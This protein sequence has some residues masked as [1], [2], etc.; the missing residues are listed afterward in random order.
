MKKEDLTKEQ[1]LKMIE[2]FEHYPAVTN[3][4]DEAYILAYLDDEACNISQVDI[5]EYIDKHFV[6]CSENEK[7][8]PIVDKFIKT[9]PKGADF[10]FGSNVNGIHNEDGT[11]WYNSHNEEEFFFNSL[12][13]LAK[14]YLLDD[15][16]V[17]YGYRYNCGEYDC[18]TNIYK[19]RENVVPAEVNFEE[20]GSDL[21]SHTK[22][23]NGYVSLETPE[24]SIIIENETVVHTVILFRVF[25]GIDDVL[26][27]FD[28]ELAE[29][30]VKGWANQNNTEGLTFKNSDDALEWFAN[31]DDK[32]ENSIELISS[33]VTTV[34]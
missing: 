31:N 12:E 11:A 6:S 24:A 13:D 7:I 20:D 16:S 33:T 25:G 19:I 23:L 22:A 2:N 28:K 8:N 29:N 27:F 3:E 21:W 10:C 18:D 34:N 4:N 30:F 26:T 17:P 1:L 9:T 15:K 32:I 5:Q 14:F